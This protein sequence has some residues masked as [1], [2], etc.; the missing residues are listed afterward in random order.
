MEMTANFW[1][2]S[3]GSG[4][5]WRSSAAGACAPGRHLRPGAGAR[6]PA[7]IHRGGHDRRAAVRQ[8]RHLWP[9]RH[10]R[11]PWTSA[12]LVNAHLFGNA[13]VQNTSGDGANAPPPACPWCWPAC[14]PPKTP[15]KAWPSLEKAP[16]RPRSS[17]SASRCRAAPSC[18][19]STTTG[20]SSIAA[21][22]SSPCCCHAGPA[23]TVTGRR[24]RRLPMAAEAT[25]PCWSACAGW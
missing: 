20:P 11:R 23:G 14:W 15:R 5:D 4:G 1:S 3:A 8:R 18:I 21:A 7:G 24:R 25:T 9:P 2:P 22:H 10:R 13:V 12:A 17:P 19:R 16:R 6:R